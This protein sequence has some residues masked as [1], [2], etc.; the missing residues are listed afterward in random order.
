[1]TDIIPELVKALEPFAAIADECDEEP[2]KLATRIDVPA[3]ID[4][5]RAARAAL[6]LARSTAQKGEAFDLDTWIEHEYA[7]N[8][9][10]IRRETEPP[11]PGEPFMSMA[12]AKE[13]TRRAVRET[14]RVMDDHRPAANENEGET[15]A[16]EPASAGL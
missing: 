8:G 7:G 10:A 12:V 2:R 11:I 3:I 6:T 4:I 1:M 9:V 16:G 5:C 14:A 13:L 15:D